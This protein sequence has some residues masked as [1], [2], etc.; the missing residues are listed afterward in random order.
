MKKD[1]ESRPA[2]RSSWALWLTGEGFVVLIAFCCSGF[3]FPWSEWNC[4]HEDIDLHT[5][6]VRKTSYF[7][8]VQ[9]SSRVEETPFSLA[10]DASAGTFPAPDWRRVNTFSPGVGR[11]PHYRYHGAIHEMKSV[12]YM[13][14][15]GRFTPEA[16]RE[17]AAHVLEL[18][19]TGRMHH[20]SCTYVEAIGKISLQNEV[21]NRATG[22]EDLPD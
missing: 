13:W 19:R 21:A 18:W 8:F 3:L 17:S 12:A 6:R 15:V 20:A 16:R 22:I 11:S 10:L 2:R 9:I 4:W 1:I 7:C 14:E 5:G